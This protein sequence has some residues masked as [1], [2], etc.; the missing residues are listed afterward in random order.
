MRN[1]ASNNPYFQFAAQLT[2]TLLYVVQDSK[3]IYIRYTQCILF[4]NLQ[5]GQLV[6]KYKTQNSVNVI[7]GGG[8]KEADFSP[9]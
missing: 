1:A 7:S 6:L 9:V 8:S 2:D 3:S 4:V 5:N